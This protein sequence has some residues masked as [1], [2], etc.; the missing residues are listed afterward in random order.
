MRLTAD[1]KLRPCLLAVDELDLRTLLRNGAS[2]ADI[3]ALLLEAVRLKPQR[4]HLAEHAQV[5]GRAM[6]QIGG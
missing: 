2:E 5:E 4:H 6:A 3:Q 1:G